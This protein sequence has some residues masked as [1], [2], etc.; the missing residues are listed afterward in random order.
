MVTDNHGRPFRFYDNRQKYLTFVTT[1]DEK[2][3][4]A[5]RTARE[6]PSLGPEPPALR[7]LDAGV[8][9]GTVLAHLLSAM[10]AAYPT[11]PF[12]VVGKEISLEDVRLT[13]EKLPDRFVEHPQT[14]VVLT[15]MNYAEAPYLQPN[16]DAKR[17]QLVFETVQLQGDSAYAFGEQLR[18]MNDF[19]A[20]H[21][22]VRM[23]ERTGSLLY[24]TPT[25]LIVHRADQAFAL[26][27][28]VPARERP[29]ADFD[30]IL[31][32]QPW[33]SRTPADFK[34]RRILAPLARALRSRGTL[35]GIQ[36]TGDDPG[37]ELI[38]RIWPGE[39]PFPVDRHQLLSVLRDELGPGARDFDLLAM[40]DDESRLRYSM[41]TLPTE[42]GNRIGTSTLFAAWNAA[43]YVA[44]IEDERVEQATLDGKYLHAT[45]DVLIERGGLWFNDETFIVRRH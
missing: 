1:C 17:V 4:V 6:L 29:R 8:G 27:N 11:I 2:W 30:L 13:L 12:Y 20:A 5:E 44:Q 18:A 16:S 24:V 19:L 14:V 21:W 26:D 38:R 28:V 10:H 40:S 39:D 23:S 45:A 22:D 7:L 37:L 33:R 43:I 9:D 32:S 36:S 34:V 31:A 3:K 15:N 25:V 42:I 41:H 35:L